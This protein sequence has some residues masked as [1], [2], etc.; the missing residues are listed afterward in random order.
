[1]SY[2]YALEIFRDDGTRIAQT[3]V[4]PDWMAAAQWVHFTGV[5]RGALPL[6]MPTRAT[7]AAASVAPVWHSD[8]GRPHVSAVRVGFP[9]PGRSAVERDIPIVYLQAV[10]RAV[11]A[12]LVADGRL[13]DGEPFRYGV[14]AYPTEAAE[15]AAAMGSFDVEEIEQPLPLRQASLAERRRVATGEA[16]DTGA[17]DLPVFLPQAIL[18]ET[19]ALARQAGDVETG[20]VLV[21]HLCR[22]PALPEIFV[23]VTTQI[24]ATHTQAHA[25]KLTFTADT[26]AA[27]RDAVALRR[28]GEVMVGW[29]HYHPDFCRVRQC[30]AERR[31]SCA[32][33]SA[34]FSSED[35]ALHATLFPRPHNTA[36][37]ISDSTTDGLRASLFGWRQ[38]MVTGRGFDTLPT[39]RQH[40]DA[41]GA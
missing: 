18:D 13:A 21:G 41:G 24:A 23:E 8:R 10:A 4:E 3:A 36:L 32:V 15:P 34:F 2:R 35:V 22:D 5:R 30:P 33:S 39:G 26:W 19:M 11:A 27:V 28:R 31:R 17:D 1:M 20:G 16:S 25:A 6:V 37:L 9:Q 7:L 40:A 29:W 12:S 38:G 14:N